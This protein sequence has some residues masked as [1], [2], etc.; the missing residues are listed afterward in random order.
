MRRISICIRFDAIDED[1]GG[2]HE[3]AGARYPPAPSAIGHGLKRHAAVVKGLGDFPGG[4]RVILPNATG[5]AGEIV[6]CQCR[7]SNE[8]Q[9]CKMRSTLAHT[10][11]DDTKSPRSAAA[12]PRFT[13]SAKRASS[14]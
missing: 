5:N 13:A 8:H 9:D 7:P 14:S 10:S 4:S 11:S 12:M 6:G 3:F 1:E 2:D